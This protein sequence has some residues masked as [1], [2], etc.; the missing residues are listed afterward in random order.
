MAEST[1]ACRPSTPV[2]S[3]EKETAR[4]FREL[5]NA[6]YWVEHLVLCADV[7][8]GPV[9]DCPVPTRALADGT[10]LE[11]LLEEAKA[12][13][14]R[15]RDATDALVRLLGVDTDYPEEG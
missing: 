10:A 6:G 15:V 2:P 14:T 4:L 12:A 13:T 5:D 9:L 11:F 7:V 3:V 8:S 1:A